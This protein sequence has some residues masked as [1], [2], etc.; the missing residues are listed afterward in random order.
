M[1]T[2][3]L[4][5]RSSESLVDC[6]DS[7]VER[8]AAA[9]GLYGIAGPLSPGNAQT[10][11]EQT[12]R[13]A[14]ALIAAGVPIVQLRD[15]RSTG[16]ELLATARELRVL[17]ERAGVLFVVNDRVDVAVLSEADGV[18]VGQDDVSIQDVRRFVAGTTW[19]RPFLVGV[20]T[21]DAEQVRVAVES[22][23]DYLGFG[24]VFETRTKEN[25]DPVRGTDRLAEAVRMAS[26]VPV[27][28]I[29]GITIETAEAVA[30][31]GAALTAIIGDVVSADDPE[32]RARELH[33][34]LS[35]RTDVATPVTER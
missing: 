3:H 32:A 30:R 11:R 8:L 35:R 10:R 6:P 31:T 22:G 18:H 5:S 12:I 14:T 26:P 17:T 25:P 20:S 28:A 4:P 15:K 27:V 19:E 29:G 34:L 7:L 2:P 21:H 23:A 33:G 1:G 9:S 24:P 16:R 13:L